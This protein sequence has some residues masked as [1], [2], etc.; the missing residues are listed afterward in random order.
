MQGLVGDVRKIGVRRIGDRSQNGNRFIDQR[1]LVDYAGIREEYQ[2][3]ADEDAAGV[4][5]RTYVV[6][7]HLGHVQFLSG[8]V[9]V[10][11]EPNL[12]AISGE[13]ASFLAGGEFPVPIVT[14]VHGSHADPES[15]GYAEAWWLP[16]PTG[17]NFSCVR[18][19]CSSTWSTVGRTAA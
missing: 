14:H 3:L 4:G 10:L 19:G 18:D 16:D 9:S 11:A 8:K 5:G 13:E 15:D 17:S 1:R 7:P 2:R 6:H 12:V